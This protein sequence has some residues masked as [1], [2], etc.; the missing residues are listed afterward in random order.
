VTTLA[1]TIGCVPRLL[2]WSFEFAVLD[3]FRISDFVLRIWLR[4]EGD[5]EK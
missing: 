1:M 3:L 2:F 4:R 5:G